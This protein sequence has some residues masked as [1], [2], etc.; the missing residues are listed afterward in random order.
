M[1]WDVPKRRNNV[2]KYGRGVVKSL[3]VL[4]ENLAPSFE[5]KRL[6]EQKKR[7]FGA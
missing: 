5:G 1:L 7:L 4:S 3:G 2:A 6:F